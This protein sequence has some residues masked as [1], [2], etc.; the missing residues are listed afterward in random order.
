M[1]QY[2]Y[3]KGNRLTKATNLSGQTFSYGYDSDGNMTSGAFAGSLSYN[4]DNEISSSGHSYDGAGNMTADNRN[5]TLS[6]NDAEQ[7]VSASEADSNGTENFSYAGTGM[8]QLLSDGTAT[9]ITYGLD[10]QDGQPW[11]Q[12]Y[13]NGISPTPIYVLRDQQGTPL[14]MEHNGNVYFFVTDNLGS[15]VDLVDTSG[16]ISATYNWDPYGHL[17]SQSGGEENYNL[18]RYTGLADMAFSP[19]TGLPGSDDTHLGD[20]WLDPRLGA[21][22][23]PDPQTILDDPFDANSYAYAA[24]DPANYI[25]PTGQ[26][27]QLNWGSIGMACAQGAAL[28]LGAGALET[29]VGIPFIAA[30]G[31]ASGGILEGMNEAYGVSGT[32]ITL[33]ENIG[34]LFWP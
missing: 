16:T 28:G 19:S 5:G 23:Q 7:L 1:L 33:I 31:C 29:L 25:D 24:D 27:G 20:R 6:Y 11:V 30:A 17:I 3:D 12:S 9:A 32:G 8:S 14:G 34:R 15:V 10:G 2:S 18:I 26:Y 22:T 13:T 21:F 4:A